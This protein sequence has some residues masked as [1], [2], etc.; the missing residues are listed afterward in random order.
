MLNANYLCIGQ[1]VSNAM[2]KEEKKGNITLVE[3]YKEFKESVSSIR[4]VVD[5]IIERH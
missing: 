4:S 3:L 2:V 5:K 1:A